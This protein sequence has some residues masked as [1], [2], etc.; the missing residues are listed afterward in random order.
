VRSDCS[1]AYTTPRGV[2]RAQLGRIPHP[3]RWR[4]TRAGLSS[5]DA[6]EGVSTQP[7]EE[8]RLQHPNGAQPNCANTEAMARYSGLDSPPGDPPCPRERAANPRL[9]P[10]RSSWSP[11]LRCRSG[12]G[13]DPGRCAWPSKHPVTCRVPANG[14]CLTMTIRNSH[15]PAG[16]RS[17]RRPQRPTTAQS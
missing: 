7:L 15:G 3:S 2:R 4:T 17:G 10:Y 14:G 9:K 13:T 5:S 6:A 16:A 12:A 11:I 8:R 1:S